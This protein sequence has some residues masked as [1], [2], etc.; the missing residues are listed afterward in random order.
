MPFL[1]LPDVRLNYVS[2]GP[3][4]PHGDRAP[5]LLVHGLAANLAFW[6]LRI[7]PALARHHRVVMLDLRGHGRSSMPRTGYSGDGI[8]ED[9]RD[10]LDHLGVDRVHIAGHSFGG[11]AALHFACL[12]PERTAS[13]TLADVRVRS[14]QP[15]VELQEWAAW[16]HCRSYFDKLGIRIDEK[17][18]DIGFELFER[19]AH[20]RL[21]QPE[22]LA[23]SLAQVASPFTGIGGEAAA[24]RWLELMA[25]TSAREELSKGAVIH[26][27]EIAALTMPALLVYGELSQ[28]LPSAFGLQKILSRAQLEIVPGAGHFFPA[29]FPDR[30]A[31]PLL[32]FVDRIRI[33]EAIAAA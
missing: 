30:L 3:N 33:P 12:F 23:E 31:A 24:R 1:D 7:A 32:A 2:M 16:P 4:E 11:N 6:Y 20:I 26:R 27:E 15:K 22:R 14:V 18:E 17:A 10:L 19:V 28:A 5:F 21:E 8:A 25:T 29:K 13:L 9:L